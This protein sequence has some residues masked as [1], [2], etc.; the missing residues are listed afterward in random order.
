MV[1]SINVKF[2]GI[3][4]LQIQVSGTDTL[5]KTLTEGVFFSS[6]IRDGIENLINDKIAKR[7]EEQTANG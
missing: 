5:V 7:V 3:Y 4:V 1:R 6:I 2:D